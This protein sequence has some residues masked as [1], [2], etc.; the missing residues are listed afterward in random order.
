MPVG[1]AKFP[2]LEKECGRNPDEDVSCAVKS[3]NIDART[4]AQGFLDNLMALP[5]A[6]SGRL[7]H[8]PSNHQ[9]RAVPAPAPVRGV[10]FENLST[11]YSSMY[12][13]AYCV[14]S[15]PSPVPSPSTA[16][17][18]EPFLRVDS[19]Q[20]SNCENITLEHVED[21]PDQ[22][23]SNSS[24]QS[25]QN[26][27]HDFKFDSVEDQGHISPDTDGSASSSRGNGGTLTRLHSMDCASIC[28]SNGNVSQVAVTRNAGESR[29]AEEIS[30]RSIQR[31]AALAKFRLKR[32]DRCYGK[33]V[34]S[35]FSVVDSSFS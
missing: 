28:V 30:Q 7:V 25:Q 19:F 20:Q 6:Q 18:R 27:N 16:G 12:P 23:A 3:Y 10:G 9:Q 17:Q 24:N 2:I 26:H 5:S 21:T 33:K 34:I 8:V 22:N 15:G 14:Q 35:I 13:Q 1:L 11:E 32:K 29:P 31:E 4:F